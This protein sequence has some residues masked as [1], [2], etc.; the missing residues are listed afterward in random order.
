MRI[1]PFYSRKYNNINFK[2]VQKVIYHYNILINKRFKLLYI[3]LNII[4][5]LIIAFKL[6]NIWYKYSNLLYISI[7]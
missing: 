6:N 7:W 2:Y 4:L 1:Y 3:K 5:Y